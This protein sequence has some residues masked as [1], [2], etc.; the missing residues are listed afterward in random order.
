MRR[1]NYSTLGRIGEPKYGGIEYDYEVQNNHVVG[2]PG[3][4]SSIH[5]HWTKGFNGQ[6][7]LSGDIY[8]GDNPRYI[9]GEYGGMY[10][11]GDAQSTKLGYYPPSTDPKMWDPT[12][13]K[14]EH[15]SPSKEKDYDMISPPDD[16]VVTSV[17]GES[18]SGKT[19]VLM[20]LI[21]LILISSAYWAKAGVKVSKVLFGR[22]RK[23][24]WKEYSLLAGILTLIIAASM[25]FTGTNPCNMS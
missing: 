7:N 4:V 20:I 2:S 22:G 16:E 6:G 12:R 8:G 5:H 1:T 15:F 3:G 19:W 23:Y 17:D 10:Q 25:W 14:K 21:F 13:P 11:V 24:G 18:S 9:S